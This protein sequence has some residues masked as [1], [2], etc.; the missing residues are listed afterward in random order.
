MTTTDLIVTPRN[1]PPVPLALRPARPHRLSFTWLSHFARCKHSALLYTRY[2]GGPASH[3]MDR[4]SVIH[5]CIARLANECLEQGEPTIP[6]DLAKAVLSEVMADPRYTIA[7]EE[8][9]Y[10]RQCVYHWARYTGLN[11]DQVLGVEQLLVWD[12]TPD[13]RISGKADF[14]WRDRET[15]GVI[16][17]KSARWPLTQEAFDNSLQTKLYSLLLAYGKPVTAEPCPACQPGNVAASDDPEEW[18]CP[19]GCNRGYIETVEPHSLGEGAQ[20]FHIAES[21]P[22]VIWDKDEPTERIASRE[23]TLTRAE[24][25]DEKAAVEALLA[26]VSEV[27]ESGQWDA[28]PGDDQCGKCP[29]RRDCPLPPVL[30]PAPGLIGTAEEA[31]HFAVASFFLE[32]E[33]KDVDAAL[34]AWN[35]AHGP[36]PLGDDLEYDVAPE[37]KSAIDKAKL[38][39][40]IAAGSAGPIEDY[41]KVSYSNR[42]MRRKTGKAAEARESK[43]ALSGA[44]GHNGDGGAGESSSGPAPSNP[45]LDAKYGESIPV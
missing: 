21:Y 40:D 23:R 16:D 41:T 18:A 26:Q 9:D 35:E 39:A 25:L 7:P 33:K 11:L 30:L 27:F 13:W 17:W 22:G 38:G 10:A 15:I 1:Q 14:C 45:D 43:E 4:G 24:L 20:F 5:D 37:R 42:F 44:S 36:I 32:S 31:E 2:G 28:V 6:F 3:E 29:A 12:A 34:K 8:W 19:H